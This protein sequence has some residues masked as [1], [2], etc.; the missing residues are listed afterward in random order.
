MSGWKK[1]GK[2]YNCCEIDDYL[3]THASN[4]LAVWLEGDIYRVF[5][6]GRDKNSRSSVGW[7]DIDILREKVV[8]KCLEA[9][10]IYSSDPSSYYSHGISIGGYQKIGAREYIF[11]MGWNVIPGDYWRGTL[12]RIELSEG[13][14]SLKVKDEKPVFGVSV[15]DPVS[16]SYPWI[17]KDEQGYK[18][19]YGSTLKW[20]SDNGEMIHVIKLATSEDGINWYSQGQAISYEIGVA[21]AFSRPCVLKDG[22]G[23]HMW[24]SYRS[25]SGEQYRIGYAFSIDGQKWESRESGIYASKGGWDSEMIC[26]PNVFDHK[27]KRY[28]LYNG[29][30]Y[31]KEGFGL[32]V[33]EGDIENG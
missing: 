16:L 13:Y 29:N 11:F 10:C 32:A 19:W 30:G 21:Q 20:E 23:Y 9:A 12:G 17:L 24:F 28:M 1:L 25:G 33:Y 4:P 6:S 2:I 8:G 5:F 31:G 3:Q 22:S 14:T 18:M 7:V 26:Y 27:G 15:A